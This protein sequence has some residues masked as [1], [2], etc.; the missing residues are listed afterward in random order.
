MEVNQ[1]VVEAKKRGATDD[2]INK[3]LMS[4]LTGPQRAV[5]KIPGIMGTAGSL[6]LSPMGLGI[7]MGIASQMAGQPVME[8]GRI[9]T[10]SPLKPKTVKVGGIPLPQSQ[11][12]NTSEMANQFLTGSAKGIGSQM[13]VNFIR[14]LPTILGSLPV[15]GGPIRQAMGNRIEDLLLKEGSRSVPARPLSQNIQEKTYKWQ[16]ERT[17]ELKKIIENELDVIKS[18]AAK[19]KIPGN[20]EMGEIQRGKGVAY[21][22]GW[23]KNAPKSQQDLYKALG[24]AYEEAQKDIASPQL[25]KAIEDYGKVQAG[26]ETVGG[27]TYSLKRLL[28]YIA[29]WWLFRK[30]TG[31]LGL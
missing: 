10:N 26:R 24:S 25:S 30:A 17:P 15:V 7:P 4:K 14:S 1:F 13:A 20:V 28:P 9:L 5:E 8:A 22:M 11:T 27:L 31:A 21:D 2:E 12:Y 29:G 19:S 16:S 18:E 3:F 6:A 23:E